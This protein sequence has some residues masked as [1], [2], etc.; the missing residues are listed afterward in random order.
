MLYEILQQCSSKFYSFPKDIEFVTQSSHGIIL[1]YEPVPN[2][3]LYSHLASDGFLGHLI[4]P[5]GTLEV[6]F[7]NEPK[8]FLNSITNFFVSQLRIYYPR[9][10]LTLSPQNTATIKNPSRGYHYELK[11][12]DQ[13][14][15]E[16][17]SCEY[18]RTEIDQICKAL[19]EKYTYLKISP[20]KYLF[21]GLCDQWI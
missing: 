3:G 21:R 6:I 16:I 7:K 11:F 15:T 17:L 9:Y 2:C 12:E 1:D 5:Y 14:P 20:K 8:K 4:T 19:C 10:S 18:S 13:L